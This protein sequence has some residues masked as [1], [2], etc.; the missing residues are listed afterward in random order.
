MGTYIVLLPF[1]GSSWSLL[2]GAFGFVPH[3]ILQ[4]KP[5]ANMGKSMRTPENPHLCLLNIPFWIYSLFCYWDELH[6]SRKSFH[7]ILECVYG[8]VSMGIQLQ[9]H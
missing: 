3:N 4:I 9:E 8:D 1:C 6:V 7:K 5:A 2:G